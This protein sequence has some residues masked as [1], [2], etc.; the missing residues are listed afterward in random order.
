MNS[1]AVFCK[2]TLIVGEGGKGGDTANAWLLRGNTPTAKEPETATGVEWN[3]NLEPLKLPLTD[4]YE[5]YTLNAN[6]D[7][8]FVFDVAAFSIAGAVV[9]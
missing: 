2:V 5:P 1:G 4:Y 8:S 6:A 7:G 9:Y 3:G